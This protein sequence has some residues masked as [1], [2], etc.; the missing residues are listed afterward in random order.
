MAVSASA[1][2][3]MAR[4]CSMGV[5]GSKSSKGRCKKKDRRK[6]HHLLCIVLVLKPSNAD[7]PSRRVLL[8]N[9][10][11]VRRRAV[12]PVLS[13]GS[14]PVAN[15]FGDLYILRSFVMLYGDIRGRVRFCGET[16]GL[17]TERRVFQRQSSISNH[18]RQ[19]GI[20]MAHPVPNF[21]PQI[22]IREKG[23]HFL[24]STNQT[25]HPDLDYKD[26]Q[27]DVN[28]N[29]GRHSIGEVHAHLWMD[30]DISYRSLGCRQLQYQ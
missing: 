10:T 2:F 22:G 19:K 3:I 28:D 24:S 30:L 17:L 26:A 23:D 11:K 7:N 5:R 20:Q 16:C 13:Y 29:I 8:S 18:L 6:F 25:L 9:N 15:F 27:K 1:Y 14:F 12:A 21:E 4:C